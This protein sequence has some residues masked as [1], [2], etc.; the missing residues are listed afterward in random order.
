MTDPT[1]PLVT[2]DQQDYAPGSTATISASGFG[3]GDDLQFQI[4]V[5]DPTTTGAAPY[6]WGVNADGSGG[7][8]TSFFVSS[9]YANTT[10]LLTVTDAA[11]GQVVQEV[12]TDG[13]NNPPNYDT[14][15]GDPGART[16]PANIIDLTA[17]TPTNVVSVG[18]PA[19]PLI[20]MARSGPRRSP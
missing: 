6:T 14:N 12:F 5:I 7:A 17:A 8:V 1:D 19:H 13:S 9:I 10:M 2:T 18:H 20:P 15:D 16:S 11:T 3:A 4:T